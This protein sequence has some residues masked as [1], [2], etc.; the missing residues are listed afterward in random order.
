MSKII[1]ILI[2]FYNILFQ[3]LT[4][5]G[6][7]QVLSDTGEKGAALTSYTND[8]YLISSTTIY[9]IINQTFNIIKDNKNNAQ[10]QN[11]LY[12]NFE[13]VESSI[14]KVKNESIILIAESRPSENKVILYSFNTSTPLEQNNN[15]L[16]ILDSIDSAIGNSNSKISLIKV[17]NDKYLLSYFLT[18]NILHNKVFKYTSYEGYKILGTFTTDVK[19]Y[20]YISCFLLYDQFPVC[21]YSKTMEINNHGSIVNKCYEN[22]IALDFILDNNY[23][24]KRECTV[25]HEL[26]NCYF[27]K[28]IYL[29]EDFAVLC[30]LKNDQK[31][32]CYV[33]KIDI[34]LSNFII[35]IEETP[36]LTI[37]EDQTCI[38]N[39]FKIDLIKV[40]NKKFIIGYVNNNNN[41]LIDLITINDNFDSFDKSLFTI[42][43]NAKSTLTLF[44][45]KLSNDYIN[46]YGIIFDDSSDNKL[47]YGYLNLPTC[48]RKKIFNIKFEEENNFKLSD[49][50]DISIENNCY[51]S[52]TIENFKII[53]F[54][55][56]DNDT[57]TFNYKIFDNTAT[58]RNIGDSIGKDE[59]L[60]IKPII[61][62]VFNSGKF[63]IEITPIFEDTNKK[64]QGR[65][66]QFEFDTI[67]YE[68]CKTCKKYDSTSNDISKHYCLS[69]KSNYYSLND[70]CLKE[71]SLIQG[72]H[73]VFKTKECIFEEL[74]FIN[75]CSYK[76]WYID[77]KNENNSCSQSSFCPENIPYVYNSTSE[78][79]ESCRYSELISGECYISN[80]IGGAT[81]AV[82]NITSEIISLGDDIFEKNDENKINKSYVIYGNNI[83][84]E[85]T[86][87]QKLINKINSNIF[88]SYIDLGECETK[89]RDIK[90]TPDDK[91][92][93]IL[94]IDLRRNDTIATQ[95]EY[96]IFD[97]ETKQLLDMSSCDNVIIQSPIFVNDSYSEKIQEIYEE[98][99][100]IFNIE[101]KFYSDLCVPFYDKKFNADL[102]L[103][104]RQL[105]YY[106]I[107]ANLCE[108]KCE[109][110][111]FN[112]SIYKAICKCPIKKEIDLDISKSDV[113]NYIE[114]NEQK[115]YYKESISNLKTVKCIKQTFSKD[116]FKYN[117]GSYFMIIMI[118]YFTI[119]AI[120]W[121]LKGEDL[122]LKYIREIL[123]IILIRID[124]GYQEKLKKRFEEMR[125]KN[126]DNNQK[127]KKKNNPPKKDNEENEIN[128]IKAND[129]DNAEK[130]N[131]IEKDKDIIFSDNKLLDKEKEYFR[132]KGPKKNA[133]LIRS[134]ALIKENEMTHDIFVPGKKKIN[135]NEK[136]TD[137][138]ID[139]LCYDKA[140]IIDH[141]GY[142]GYYWSMLKLRQLIIFTFV[143]SKD[144]YNFIFI[145]IIS[146]FLLLSLNLFYNSIFFFDKVINDIYDDEGKYSIKLQIL[147]ILICS[148]IFSFTI[149]LVRF[150][151]TSHRKYIKL[152]E[153][154]V[155]EEA[156]KESY[157]IH[158]KLVIRYIIFISVGSVL[159]LFIWYFITSFCAIY[160]YTQNHM[161]LNAFISF[162]F[163]MIYQ[164]IYCLLPALFRYLGLE[165][166]YKCC[167]CFSQYI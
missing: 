37:N 20:Y 63:F 60:Q 18:G 48:T 103:E 161:F 133:L 151:I 149:I 155:Y 74:E 72:Y 94:K 7:F 134:I 43:K 143:V 68:G 140:K 31:L 165:K 139:S 105:V 46:N 154:D 8:L 101:E 80:I 108:A 44:V 124:S 99:Y 61:E 166:N 159:I 119:F 34:D 27:N 123:D 157:S 24:R 2:T 117:W 21:Y 153:M 79:I 78:C 50:I 26:D 1:I 144:D 122:I 152:K 127:N 23:N 141:R 77:Q 62:N 64:I 116:G 76:I 3:I 160:R 146:F 84:I 39:I 75:D 71:C 81:D 25:S 35:S 22:L 51:G 164:F 113:F 88:V 4:I 49:Y 137:I 5:D 118:I 67:C 86:D 47:K 96:K 59:Q 100:D 36:S 104:K 58:Q 65:S 130:N 131:I 138:E 52:L 14:N 73:D 148:L 54:I 92:L 121:F 102:T 89:L 17:G 163:S 32:Y 107:N 10:T 29:S 11:Q 158:K 6:T 91:E 12:K 142:C 111:T 145:K 112:M 16:K 15:N 120:I 56:F 114:E 53:S 57:N 150:I 70:L 136:L 135:Y 109:Y 93:I 162:L 83:T 129:L 110:V 19:D 90:N 40:S 125:S 128:N 98:G 97:S 42:N 82:G 115:I 106:Y 132:K 69:C 38:N 156:Q 147:N 28:A 95:V 30:H 85:I 45:H 87:T 167:Y 33:K 66:C 126:K 41:I 55:A 9:N 13:I